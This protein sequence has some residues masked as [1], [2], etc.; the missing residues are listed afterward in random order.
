MDLTNQKFYFVDKILYKTFGTEKETFGEYEVDYIFLCK[1]NTP[2]VKY[3]LVKDE[4]SEVEWVSR[5]DL[6][7][8]VSRKLSEGCQFSPWFAKMQEHGLL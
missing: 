2:D 1:L 7:D 3:E 4:I 6:G 8:F 5:K